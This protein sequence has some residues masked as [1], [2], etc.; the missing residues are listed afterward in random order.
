MNSLDDFRKRL[1]VLC[2]KKGS[3]CLPKKY[4]DQQI[5]FKSVILT[6]EP[7]KSYTEIQINKA[8]KKWLVDIGRE[9]EV[10]HVTLRRALCDEKYLSRDD[11]G[12]TYKAINTRDDL[13]EPEINRV[14]PLLII[15]EAIEL[16]E[17]KKKQFI[18]KKESEARG[19]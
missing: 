19:S 3:P 16:R 5:L 1:E 10:D 11:E 17:Q 18:E 15:N 4:N 2:L 6:L 9:I 8:I 14:D 13:F 12:K 7:E